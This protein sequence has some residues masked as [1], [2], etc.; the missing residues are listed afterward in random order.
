MILLAGAYSLVDQENLSLDF[1]N[2]EPYQ[3]II[4]YQLCEHGGK[5]WD[6]DWRSFTF[7]AMSR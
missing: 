2:F 1:N 6:G 5:L 3:D 4:L 7:A